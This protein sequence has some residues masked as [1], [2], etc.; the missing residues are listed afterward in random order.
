M[1]IKII[2]GISG[3]SGTIYGIKVLE[4]AV[5]LGIE[6]HLIVT[7]GAL[8]TFKTEIDYNF[9]KLQSLATNFYFDED[10]TS[11]T[12]IRNTKFDGMV[13]APCSMK[14]LGGIVTGNLKGLIYEAVNN[15]LKNKRKIILLVRETPLN[16]I[17]MQ[18]MEKAAGM[19]IIVMPPVPAFYIKPETLEEILN[20]TIGR[21]FD[22]LGIDLNNFK[23]WE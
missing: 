20:Q 7:R 10:F 15:L 22:H 14:T 8:N 2:I 1:K 13:I 18:N 5:N 11:L 3:A 12:K 23:R 4:T 9:A 21:V 16:Q 19:G 6:T 17:H